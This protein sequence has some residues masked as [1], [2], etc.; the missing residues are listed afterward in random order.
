VRRI[1]SSI[2]LA[3]GAIVHDEVQM[4]FGAVNGSGIG[5]FGRKSGIAESPIWA[6]SPCK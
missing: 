2:C 6:G 5:R 1:D 4:P 3:N